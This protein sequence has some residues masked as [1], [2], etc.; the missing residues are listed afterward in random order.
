MMIWLDLVVVI[1]CIVVGGRVGGI[2]LGT[3][4][5]L[6]LTFFVFGLGR[7]PGQF[8]GEVLLIV[9]CVV[10]LAAALQAAGGLDLMVSIAEKALRRHP[11]HITLL[12][13]FISYLF[14]FVSGTG[15]VSYSL[16]PI[17]AEVARKVK[18]RPERP[19]SI[20]VIASQAAV[21]ASPM[22]AATVGM[23]ALLSR[24]GGI[25]LIDVLKICVP[26]TLI[27]VL[28]GALAVRKMGVELAV[29][30]VFRERDR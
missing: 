20:S 8:P 17:I 19:L 5:A 10:T 4:A 23:V 3:V 22:S 25:G 13:P 18:E 26:S 30:P 21:T 15:H 1:A 14:T 29:D 12:A 9:L 24:A 11:R 6:G 28:A 7:A 2:G 27:G 16:L